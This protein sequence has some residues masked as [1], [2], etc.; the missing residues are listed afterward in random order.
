MKSD[1]QIRE[2]HIGVFHNFMDEELIDRYLK[3][4]HH[5]EEQGLVTPR[6]GKPH[7]R[8][9]D[10]SINT[11][12][13]HFYLGL[14]YVSK[15]FIDFFFSKIYPLYIKKY[16]LLTSCDHHTIYDIRVQKT[17]PGE[18][19]HEWHIENRTME[20]RN[21]L[22][23]FMVYLNDVKEGGETEFLYQKCRFKPQRNTF[24]IWPALYTHA[25]RGNPP[26]SNDKYIL[27]GWI[28]YGT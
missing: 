15:P 27:T 10:H 21:R 9:A 4:Y 25:H 18:G 23:A 19:F 3:H 24:L 1:F 20:T 14:P 17:I 7:H 28:E 12:D 6:K 5:A 8:W 2:D 22:M 13:S 16:S 11:M 26:L